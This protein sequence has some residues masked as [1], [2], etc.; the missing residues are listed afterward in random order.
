[1]R[2][3]P[4][5]NVQIGVRGGCRRQVD[6]TA[7]LPSATEIPCAP[8]QLRLVPGTDIWCVG[9]G[10]KSKQESNLPGQNWPFAILKTSG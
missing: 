2:A 1:M 7:R 9:I 10:D 4:N 3:M 8:R 5:R 6:G